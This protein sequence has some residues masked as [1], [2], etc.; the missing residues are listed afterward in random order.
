[1]KWL[2]I[3]FFAVGVMLAQVET[4]TSITGTVTDQQ[5]AAFAGASVKLRIKTLAPYARRLR[6]ARACILFHRCRPAHT[7]HRLRQ[8]L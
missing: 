7:H 2:V 5:G 3:F 8:R 1:M 6:T 4:T